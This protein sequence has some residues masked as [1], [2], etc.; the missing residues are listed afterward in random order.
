M[1]AVHTS[2]GARPVP[3]GTLPKAVEVLFRA[4]K[5]DPGVT[6]MPHILH[7]DGTRLTERE[8]DDVDRLMGE[9]SDATYN[10]LKPLKPQSARE[11]CGCPFA[12][13]VPPRRE[14]A[15]AMERH[16]NRVGLA[17]ALD[18]LGVELRV[19]V[20]KVKGKT[21]F[22]PVQSDPIPYAR[23]TGSLSPRRESLEAVRKG[24]P[25]ANIGMMWKLLA[26]KFYA[27]ADLPI[28]GT[29]EALQ[30]S[31]DAIRSGIKH[32]KTT[33]GAGRF[34]TTWDADAKTLTWED[35]GI[36]MTAD[37]VFD[38]FL[39][40]GDS[41]KRGAADSEEAA[42][43][44]GVA[45]AVI[46]GVSA[47]F[48]WDLY[49][50]DSVYRARGFSEEI[51]QHA[52]SPHLQGTRLVMHNAQD[53][54]NGGYE[55]RGQRYDYVTGSYRPTN[56]RLREMLSWNDLPDVA[57]IYNGQAIPAAFSRRHGATIPTSGDWGQGTTARV[58]TYR[59]APGDTGGAYYIRLGGLFQFRQ[60]SGSG[61]MKVD[62][63]IDLTTTARPESKAYPLTAARDRLQSPASDRFNDLS[64]E[65]ERENESTGEDPEYDTYLPP[66]GA[67]EEPSEETRALE[68]Q[69][70]AAMQDPDV[71][72][73]LNAARGGVEDYY[74]EMLK[75][76]RT[77]A[78]TESGAAAGT[79]TYEE[80]AEQR[81][82]VL[83][84]GFK[85]ADQGTPVGAGV[86]P[87]PAQPILMKDKYGDEQAMDP[88]LLV[89]NQLTGEYTDK[90]TGDV[91]T[92]ADDA[93]RQSRIVEVIG[94]VRDTLS[95]DSGF[96]SYD[97]RE[98]LDRVEGTGAITETDASR[99][100]QAIH[101]KLE[102][103]TGAGGGGLVQAMQV[104]GAFA[105]LDQIPLDDSGMSSWHRG[106][107]QA[108]RAKRIK[109]RRFDLF[110]LT[111]SKKHYDT[112]KAYR[113]KKN[114]GKWIPY[115]LVWDGVL[116][117][118]ATAAR[119]RRKFIA[120]FVLHDKKMA[121][122]ESIGR[123]NL[124]YIHPDRFASAVKANKERPMAVAGYLHGL[125]CH[126]L[127]HVDGRMGDG[128]NEEFISSRED[129]GAATSYLLPA[130]AVLAEKLLKLT[131]P[132]T[133]AEREVKRLRKALA[134][135][136]E[137][138][139]RDPA[140]DIRVRGLQKQLD[141]AGARVK[142][143]WRQAETA[144]EDA[145][146]ELD[147]TIERVRDEERT[148]CDMRVTAA[149]ERAR[150]AA[151]IGLASRINHAFH[152]GK[153]AAL[154]EL[155][156]QGT[157]N[158]GTAMVVYPRATGRA[159]STSEVDVILDALQEVAVRHAS[160]PSGTTKAILRANRREAAQ[161]L[162]ARYR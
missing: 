154:S 125:A 16:I 126:E 61:K 84:A 122:T 52:A 135:A 71:I 24:K 5:A 143:A 124:V 48:N 96:V 62:V 93:V 41:G 30:N 70:Q 19:P 17:G 58:K 128:H 161:A 2:R 116:R 134:K 110:P 69:A 118:V 131:P 29:R 162:T 46:L 101:A 85:G 39:S 117:M 82:A 88:A 155:E 74:A 127:T 136:K 107:V 77:D 12:A 36:G 38:K 33:T 34:S 153:A 4:G 21:T 92:F 129:L 121:M 11:D 108:D 56:D 73:A 47:N 32:R 67:D 133:N 75:Q 35:N 91:V 100:E 53:G 142:E 94:Q 132:E 26:E 144:R 54:S 51:E 112:K 7:A 14:S 72:A 22:G 150:E 119:I 60:A 76:K 149:E 99:L 105:A 83:P 55:G 103:A 8:N 40:I 90:A 50:L 120:G 13:P 98:V 146:R 130:F 148:A 79:R 3:A 115:L 28:V 157:R 145:L 23:M 81:G 123:R 151:R 156:T 65:I 9:M 158:V 27:D 104:Q 42:G 57:L 159:P 31:L 106:D 111:I 97:I 44:F 102:D 95:D 78:P 66:A 43:G 37:V 64:T 141:A 80:E 137:A 68:E 114:Y 20:G 1:Y 109:A 152:E 87:Q 49:S 15:S 63:V 147:S 10:A 140:A 25:T 6:S 89:Y 138:R 113:F 160:L 59:R 139:P 18:E 86:T 45:K